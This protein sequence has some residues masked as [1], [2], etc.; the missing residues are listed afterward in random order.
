[1][2]GTSHTCQ[3]ED[4]SF[5]RTTIITL[6]KRICSGE[7]EHLARNVLLFG[8]KDDL[9]QNFHCRSHKK[10]SGNIVMLLPSLSKAQIF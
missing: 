1:M 4:F 3:K 7:K 5:C 10:V 2:G 6:D 9:R 8:T